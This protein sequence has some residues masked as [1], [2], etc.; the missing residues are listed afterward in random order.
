MSNQFRYLLSAEQVISTLLR[1]HPEAEAMERAVGG[2]YERFGVLEHAVLREAGLTDESSVVDVGCGSGR[3]AA[4][5]AGRAGLRYLGT[6]VVP[7]MLDYARRQAGRPDFRFIHVDRVNIPAADASA[8]IVAFFSVLTHLLH[9]ES[10]LYLQEA[11]RVLKPGGRVV[12]SFLEYDT[13]IGWTVFEANL[14]WVRKRIVASQINVFL[15]RSEIRL[16][17]RRLGLEVEVLRAGEPGSV[18]VGAGEATPAMPEGA[19]AFGQSLCILR[20]PAAGETARTSHRDSTG[21]DG[22]KRDPTGR[23][24]AK[25]GGARAAEPEAGGRS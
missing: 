20:K 13:P 2:D 11:A 22:A 1:H 5:L 12:F 18:E 10:Y 9:E 6:D 23:D 17:A 4:Q 16:W 14:D 7:S 8:D 24:G 21:R 19:Y 15:H 3:L 25:R